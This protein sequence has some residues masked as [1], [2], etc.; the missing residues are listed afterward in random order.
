MK[1]QPIMKFAQMIISTMVFCVL[2][3]ACESSSGKVETID[4]EVSSELIK[5]AERSY[6]LKLPA[7]YQA[8][9]KYKLL[10]VFHGSGGNALE[11]GSVARFEQYSNEYIVAY[12]NSKEVEWDEGCE[13]NIAHR[14]NA[15]DL[16]FVDAVIADIKKQHQISEGEIYAAGFSQGGLFTQNLACNRSEVFKAVAVVAGSMSVQLAESCA[17]EE[18]VSVMM[19]HGEDDTVL[20]YHGLVH[21]NFGLISSPDAI[22]LHAN[23]HGRLP[24]PLYEVSAE[25]K[26]NILKYNNGTQKFHLY[27]A[28]NGGHNWRF[29]GFD[30]SGQIL[31]FFSTLSQAELPEYSQLVVTEQG[32]FHVRA[33]GLNNPGPAVVL[34][35]GPNYNYHSDSAWFAALQPLLAQQY[36]VYSIDRLGNAFSSSANNVSYHRFSDDLALVLQQLEETQLMLVAFSSGSI[37]ARWFYQKYQQQFD[38]K[39]MVYIDPD[40]PLAHSLSLYQGYP[41]NWY[42]ANLAELVPFIAEGNWTGRTKDKLDIEYSEL[43]QLAAAYNVQVDWSYFEQ[44]IQRRLLI[45][46]Q[47]ARAIE[48]A[49]YIE[50]LDGYASLPM[51]STIPVSVIDSDFEQ[52]QINQ[53]QD[54]PE[55]MAAL[56]LW[57]QEGSA[58]SAEQAS[59]SNGQYIELH[60][61]DHLVSVQ[62]P[63][64]IKQALDW[65]FS[66]LQLP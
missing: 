41:A 35:A 59:L 53:A 14:K 63:K 26:V 40:I 49:N 19:V 56:Q 66:Q 21:S 15:N 27:T 16:G 52:Q 50:D 38:I 5:L 17:P 2:L 34:L 65:L 58:W 8:E 31:H 13:C 10:L 18:A 23:K 24:Y 62:Q 22:V 64:T 29:N 9:N 4:A 47:Q 60:D 3:S 33:M 57:Q 20:P 1:L 37:S 46:Q 12:P 51:V 48:I 44:I 36:R 54:E 42:Q 55:L 45:P 30:T 39:A 61:S 7:D 43:K 11:M 28:V 32:Q 25:K 6:L